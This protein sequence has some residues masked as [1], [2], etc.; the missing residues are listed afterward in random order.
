MAAEYP[1]NLARARLLSCVFSSAGDYAPLL[2]S[3]QS[4]KKQASLFHINDRCTHCGGYLGGATL[5]VGFDHHSV[6]GD[7]GTVDLAARTNV[8]CGRAD[9]AAVHYYIRVE[10]HFSIAFYATADACSGFN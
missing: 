9:Q 2:P 5:R 1:R 4:T 7:H 3:P 8:Y 10:Y 6:L